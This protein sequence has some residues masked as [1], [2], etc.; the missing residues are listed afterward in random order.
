MNHINNKC[1]RITSIPRPKPTTNL[2]T[3][4]EMDVTVTRFINTYLY[5]YN[6]YIV[7]VENIRTTTNQNTELDLIILSGLINKNFDKLEEKLF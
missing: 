6:L 2:Q 7:L 1:P 4:N 5:I 3:F